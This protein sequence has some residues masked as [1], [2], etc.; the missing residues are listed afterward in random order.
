MTLYD[1]DNRIEQLIS[2][3]I[4]EE[5]GELL[6]NMDDLEALN[7]ERELKIENLALYI[8]NLRAEASAIRDEEKALAA[9]RKSTESIADRIE[10]ALSI[11]LS[12][13]KFQ[14]ARVS[15]SFRSSTAVE[16]GESFVSWASENMPDLLRYKEP[17]ADKKAIGEALKK[18][19]EIPGA[20]LVN[21]TSMII[22]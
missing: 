10:K 14:T 17:E 20:N 5:T 12:G 9:R 4:D 15:V 11:S 18:G 8:K 19:V 7:A 21:R 13:N 3:S 2:D 1:I 6:L 16:I 22:K